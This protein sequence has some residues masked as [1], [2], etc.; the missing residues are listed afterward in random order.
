QEVGLLFERLLKVAILDRDV[1]D[2]EVRQLH[3]GQDIV[4]GRFMSGSGI[5]EQCRPHAPNN[6]RRWSEFHSEYGA[7]D[8]R[9]GSKADVCGAT[10]HVRFTPNSDRESRHPQP[11]MSALPP[12]ADM[13]GATRDVRFGP[14]A[15][16]CDLAV[17]A[18]AIEPLTPLILDIRSCGPAL[19]RPQNA[20]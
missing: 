7:T 20:D 19:P 3:R 12:I 4:L 5:M 16:I 17:R 15:D 2:V 8:V 9:F 18:K 11:F 1:T 6:M 14:I 13:C 10:E